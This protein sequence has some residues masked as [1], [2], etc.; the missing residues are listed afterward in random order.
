MDTSISL[1]TTDPTVRQLLDQLEETKRFR[2]AYSETYLNVDQTVRLPNPTPTVKEVLDAISRATNTTYQLRGDQIIFRKKGAKFTISGYIRDAASGEDLIGATVWDAITASG[3][4]SNTYG[5]YSLTLPAGDT[6]RLRASYVGHVAQEACFTLRQDTL[7]DWNL[8][9]RSLDEVVVAATGNP[10]AGKPTFDLPLP[11]GTLESIPTLLGEVDVL[12]S[13]QRLPGVQ[14]GNDGGAGLYVRGSGPDQNLIL[15]DGVPVYNA[16]HLFGFFS[17]FNADAVNQVKFFKSG[18]PA[19]YGGR[20]SSVVDIQ[21]KEGNR[22][23]FHGAGSVGLLSSKLTLEGPIIKDKT[24]FLVS[25]R[26][27]YLDLPLRA[28]KSAREGDFPLYSFY[29]LTAKV[30]HTFSPRDQVYLSAYAGRDRLPAQKLTVPEPPDFAT[31]SVQSTSVEELRWGNVTTAL[32]WNHVYHPKWFS[33]LT[34]TRSRYRFQN[35]DQSLT[36]RS[37][38]GS[39]IISRS[40]TQRSAS[41]HNQALR[42]DVDYLPTPRHYVR[43]GV[44]VTGHTFRPSTERLVA[45][46]GGQIQLD[47]ALRT[48]ATDAVEYEAFAEDDLKLSQSLRMT[49]GLRFTHFQTASASY[50]AWQPRVQVQYRPSSRTL[51]QVSYTR[52]A[53]FIHLLTNPSTPLPSDLWLPT[54]AQI[55]PETAHQWTLGYQRTLGKFY[56]LQAEAYYKVMQQVV[57]YKE[58][59]FV[60]YDAKVVSDWQQQVASGRGY[61]YGAELLAQKQRGRFT[62]WVGYTWLRSR[63]QFDDINEGQWFPFKYDRRHDVDVGGVFR[64][65]EHIN[66]TFGWGLASGFALT[67]P[68]AAITDAP[69][70]PTDRSTY[71]PINEYLVYGKRNSQRTRASHRLDVSIAFRKKK[72]WGE[73]TWEVSV[74]NVYS[75]KNPFSVY[76]SQYVDNSRWVRKF[77]QVSLLPII[78]SVSYRFQF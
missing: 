12:K 62:G 4:S 26:R 44:G 24:S 48:S 49:A 59:S 22:Q 32:R 69:S 37:S 35:D 64:W 36:V 60:A 42:L 53:Q 46:T 50:A 38:P 21:L 47:T 10:L 11:L 34:L 76:F 56:S 8:A 13:L 41:V 39:T 19:R 5:F 18:F 43:F 70:P 16:S 14:A 61:S 28:I 72:R 25:A 15:L 65:K 58:G 7:V 71:Y 75:R 55:P 17:V 66:V 29:D 77:Y 20:L 6:V 33:N 74:Y 73:R 78:P 1:K 63:R 68:R 23:E 31:S 30:N 51:S 9:E 40:T 52:M 57:E 54:T 27:T 2:L 3:T 45:G 67:L